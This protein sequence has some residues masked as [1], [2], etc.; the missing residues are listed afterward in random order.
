MLGSFWNWLASKRHRKPASARERLPRPRRRVP[1]YIESLESRELLA[2]V[3]WI[4]PFGGDWNVASN[5]S[6]G[7][8]PG[9]ADDVTIAQASNVT[10]IANGPISTINNFT[11]AGGTLSG[12]GDLTVNGVTTITA[13]AMTGT[14]KTIAVNGLNISGFLALDGR[15]LENRALAKLVNDPAGTSPS[16]SLRGNAA[17]LNT[18]GAIWDFQAD[19]FVE[20]TDNTATSFT[21]FGTVKKTATIG[22][23]NLRAAFTNNGSVSVE[24]GI[25]DIKTGGSATGAFTVAAGT[26]LAFGGGTFTV[27]S[28]ATINGAGGTRFSGGTTNFLAGSTFAATGPI[29]IS[30]GT[31][32]FST[33]NP[34]TVS[35]LTQNSGTLTGSD[36]LTVIGATNWLGGTMSG[37]GTTI[38]GT[39][40]TIMAANWSATPVP[41]ATITTAAPHLFV[42]GDTV[43][44]SGMTPA[45][46]N[47]VFTIVSVPTAT[48]FTYALS[49]TITAA[50][51]NAGAVTLTTSLAH[52]YSIGDS[53]VISGMVPAAYNGT[54]VVTGRTNTT[55][56][57]ALASNPG[58]ATTFGIAGPGTAIA[59]GTATKGTLLGSLTLGTNLTLSQRTLQYAGATPWTMPS[60]NLF[61]IQNGGTFTYPGGVGSSTPGLSVTMTVIVVNDQKTIG[62]ADPGDTLQ[63]TVTITNNGATTAE[64]LVFTDTLDPNTTLLSETVTYPT[65][66]TSTVITDADIANI[67]AAAIARWQAAGISAAQLAL[68]QKLTFTRADLEGLKVTQAVGN[69]V[70]IDQTAANQGWFV[71]ASPLD[72]AEFATVVTPTRRVVATL[73]AAAGRL[74][75]LTAIMRQMGAIMGITATDSP[76]LMGG[77]LNP[78]TRN[79]PT[80]TN[81]LALLKASGGFYYIGTYVQNAVGENEKWF[82]DRNDNFYFILPNGNLI[83]WDGISI[84]TSKANPVANLGVAVYDDPTLLFNAQAVIAPAT[85]AVM[86]GLRTTHG[87]YTGGD[88][89]KNAF[90]VNE[91]WF[92]DRSNNLYFIFT[93][94][95]VFKWDGISFAT[96]TQISVRIA[97]LGV[98]VYDDPTLLFNAPAMIAPA[99]VT[100][101]SQLRA[102]NGFYFAGD[103]SKNVT[104][105]NE[106]W[107][108]D[109]SNN[110]FFILPNGDVFKW[111][112][113]SF[114]TSTVVSLRIA[115]LGV[116]VYDD[117][118]QLFNAPITVPAHVAD[119]LPQLRTT[120]GFKYLGSYFQNAFGANEKWFQDRNSN[121]FIILPNG[122]LLRWDGISFA[123]TRSN[124][125]VANLGAFVYDDPNL[126]FNADLPTNPASLAQ[127]EFYRTTYG[128]YYLGTYHQSIFGE[129]EKW[130]S[131]RT[132]SLYFLLTNGALIKWN[133]ISFASSKASPIANLGSLV[134]DDPNVLFNANVSFSSASVT[135]LATLRTTYGF[136]F[137]GQFY[138]NLTGNNEKWFQD[139]N[140]NYYFL[141]SNGDLIKWDA[142][143]VAT[144]KANPV[145]NVGVIVYDDP[146]LLFNRQAE[147]AT[148]LPPLGSLG[149]G[150]SRVIT[151]QARINDVLPAGVITISNQGS[152]SG[153][154][155]GTQTAFGPILT[156]DPNVVGA[157]DP[158]RIAVVPLSVFDDPDLENAVNVALGLPVGH[159]VTKAELLLL[160][161]LTVDG[162]L[163]TSLKGLEWAINLQSLNLLPS[164]WNVTTPLVGLGPISSLTSLRSLAIVKSGVTNAQLVQLAGL[165]GLRSL[166]LRYNA[167]TSLTNIANLPQLGTLQIYGNAINDFTPIAGKVID[168]DLPTVNADKA[169]TVAELAAALYKSPIEILQYVTNN[170]QN[171]YYNGSLKGPQATLETLAGNDWDQAILLKSL[172]D[173]SGVF[174]T[175]YISGQVQIPVATAQLWFGVNNA[176]AAGQ[177]LASLGLNPQFFGA[178]NESIRFNHTWVQM[179]TSAI[180]PWIDLDP[181]WKFSDLQPG[182]PNLITN[183][184]FD[185]N[186]FL[187]TQASAGQNAKSPAEYYNEQVSAYLAANF[188]GLTLADVAKS[189]P[190]HQQT[191][192]AL[193][194][195]TPFTVVG[196]LVFSSIVPA[197]AKATLQITLAQ[198]G[199]IPHFQHTLIVPDVSLSRITIEYIP[200]GGGLSTPKLLVDG[201][202][203]ATSPTPVASGAAMTLTLTHSVPGAVSTQTSV[204]N[205]TAGQTLAIGVNALQVSERLL[206]RQRDAINEAAVAKING[207]TID[208]NKQIGAV[209][210]LG[211]FQWFDQTTKAE[212]V[213]NGMT[214]ALSLYGGNLTTAVATS[215]S[216]SDA[217]VDFNASLQIPAV[218]RNV[219]LEVQNY[220]HQSL[221]LSADNTFNN[222]RG[223]LINFNASEREGGVWEELLNVPSMS[224]IKSL[225]RANALLIP[226][227]TITSA[228]VGTEIP[229]LTHDNATKTLI[230]TE[231]ANG[232]TVTVPRDPTPLNTFT[233]VGYIA[234]KASG[235]EKYVVTRANSGIA[236]LGAV[237]TSTAVAVIPVRYDIDTTQTL[238]D[239]VNIAS[240]NVVRT[241]KDIN[242]P[243]IGLPLAFTRTYNS[244]ST[245]DRGMGAGWSFAFGDFLTFNGGGSIGWTTD[246]GVL[247]TFAPDGL[248]GFTAPSTIH[249]SFTADGGGYT[250]RDPH[251]LS[252]RFDLDGKLTTI[253]DRN[254]NA[255]NITYNG[256]EIA[257]VTS[258]DPATHSLAFTYTAG[259]ITSISDGTGR[260]WTYTYVGTTLTQAA[261]PGTP[262][263]LYTYFTD[264]ALGGLLKQVTA[265]DGGV[266][267][268]AYYANRRAYQVVDPTGDKQSFSYNLYRNQTE[269]T[270]QRGNSTLYTLNIVGNVTVIIYADGTQESF[271]W[272]NN[273]KQS[274]TDVFSQ[275]ETYAYDANGNL[276]QTT[277]RLG[278]VTTRTYESS[279]NQ[280]ATL[281]QLGGRVTT[282]GYDANGNLTSITDA[283]GRITAMTYSSTGLVLTKTTPRGTATGTVGDYTTTYT[284]NGAGQILTIS[285]D[286][287]STESYTYD[288]RGRMITHTDARNNT[289]TFAYD[290]LDRLT[291]ITD[292]FSKVTTHTYDNAGNRTSTT[293]ALGRVTLFAYDL[294]GHLIKTTFADGSFTTAQ[295]DA[296]G[297]LVSSTDELGRIS[298]TVYDERN[299][300]I[301][302]IKADGT[303]TLTRYDGDVRV[304]AT[305]DEKGNVTKYTYDK[306]GRL[307][308]TVNAINGVTTRTYDAVGNLLTISDPLARV[309]TYQYD[310]LNRKTQMK[311]A[312]NNITNYTYDVDG[313]L[314]TIAAPLGETTQFTYDVLGRQTTETNALNQ[315]VTRTYDAVGNLLSIAGPSNNVTTHAYDALNR[316]ITQTNPASGA[317]QTLA[318]DFVGNQ[319][320]T[321]DFLGRTTRYTYD[322]RNRKVKE[323][324]LDGASTPIYTMSFSHDVAGQLTG[325]SD[326]SATYRYT[327]DKVG[328]LVTADNSFGISNTL[329]VQQQYTYDAAGN[330]LSLRDLYANVLHDNTASTY[331]AMNRTTRIN[332]ATL[333]Y[334]AASQVTSLSRYSNAALTA[335]VATGAYTYDASGNLTGLIYTRPGS[336]IVQNTWTYNA[337][338]RIATRVSAG[339]TS[340]YT[341]DLSGQLLTATQP[342]ETYTYDANGN[343]TGGGIVLGSGNR[344]LSDGTF[345]YTYDN[346]GNV[347]TQTQIAG[348]AVTEY[349][350][351]YRN[352]LTKATFRSNLGVVQKEVTYTYDMFDRRIAK[353]VDPDGPGVQGAVTERYVYNGSQIS[354]QFNGANTLTHQFNYGPDGQILTDTNAAGVTLWA[355]TDNIGS[356][357]H[358]LNSASG[359]VNQIAYNSFG[360]IVSESNPSANFLFGFDGMVIDRDTGLQ[361]DATR[362]YS[363]RIGRYVSQNALSFGVGD[364]NLYRF[365]TNNPL[366]P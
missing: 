266:S 280:I 115:Q 215:D 102:A 150:Q 134:Y 366:L 258:S 315:T 172:L 74:D 323:E 295:W 24:A 221:D 190:I 252:H 314:I 104:G 179:Q 311:D 234:K 187:I 318:Y 285:T 336:T 83:R 235:Q 155:S 109:R 263:T 94:G 196:N 112:G 347:L 301:Q 346:A 275:T 123:S 70:A 105:N 121:Y 149:A 8:V 75:L 45:G 99:T 49:A 133:G 119:Y 161:S 71:D 312:L 242:L 171:Q 240:G 304:G 56:T 14:G 297:N 351:D 222:S 286:L 32:N 92:F 302:T 84:P 162:N 148:D 345:T 213:I 303:S 194:S 116:L 210:A 184:F 27:N 332:N 227:R 250:Y 111:D 3:N 34:I 61:N 178:A 356:V 124:H 307:L 363:P 322:L 305:T 256:T 254:G 274:A 353:A 100:L 80:T 199:P 216:N 335:L 289:T 293:D 192:T 334:D 343:R 309:T 69:V 287:P 163:I 228:N 36:T 59:F 30:G 273:L 9:A 279:F 103:F 10:I 247:H 26:T 251:G 359:V 128:F 360:V 270:D 157:A 16:I 317:T 142:I 11:L 267:T 20:T 300:V 284:Y 78:G 218:P 241:E 82:K 41:T 181:T 114:A 238:V 58:P 186:A 324:W 40:R 316:L 159:T 277:D 28:G 291:S 85:Q 229:L 355:L 97:Q 338:D 52:G 328:Q 255:L 68:L 54:F 19:S 39:S 329:K 185:E 223:H 244:L 25:L 325:A 76:D 248:G 42:V 158:T 348:G 147:F 282:Y 29:T 183:V 144:S 257:T 125:L 153:F 180:S 189:G 173:A 31:V 1:L 87:F 211:L 272:T 120:Y 135:Q 224:A 126:L 339:V 225:E 278:S 51:W 37:T 170:V 354:L 166:D 66:V 243:A 4:N 132:G 326:P 262:A 188:P 7:V 195:T 276:T 212:A 281:T 48:T 88:Y 90:G 177:L 358:V 337:A 231:V 38:A 342:S 299:R 220:F 17:I 237:A 93:N 260:T 321:I 330:V 57:F 357:R 340:T 18:A 259:H 206:A 33:G 131:D 118:H 298:I 290:L 91:K 46:F 167:I 23:V 47:G 73:N 352:R 308:T 203:V 106:K 22:A 13:G 344:I 269:Y 283:N 164:D 175:R 264:T 268:F 160:T 193:P 108:K 145:A 327:Y 81:A 2:N 63:Y 205:R 130:F 86:T 152:V 310:L 204:Y 67:V 143:S 127:L 209:L 288:A 101:M 232:W 364:P 292:P 296:A 333:T 217:N 271:V 208:P 233:G 140:Q 331:D 306:L 236:I 136:Y 107:F 65:S 265:S 113:I 137:L 117:P 96:S 226:V 197:T 176:T 202:V 261:A 5:W 239:G 72:D 253:T 141:L 362:Y 174:G 43:T 44:I 165:T 129:N 21:N 151:F 53:V 341:Y 313:N 182:V 191:F 98:A 50:S 320:S 350:W 110:Y 154:D 15:T 365:H 361:Y 201:V 89:F 12:T 122:D 77:A 200:A 168:L 198:P 79:T 138:N 245:I 219:S 95:D 349:T 207:T 64:N 319:T 139:R 214:G 294:D 62:Q 230:Q 55:F 246:T 60:S 35:G 6:T 249:G 169:K 156:D 146:F